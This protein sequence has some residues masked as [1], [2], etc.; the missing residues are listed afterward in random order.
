MTAEEIKKVKEKRNSK[1][2]NCVGVIEG[3]KWL[4]KKKWL[5][6]GQ[7]ITNH[8]YRRIIRQ[9]NKELIEELFRRGSVE[10]PWGL[11]KLQVRKEKS[12]I[13]FKDGKIDT[14]LNIDWGKTVKLWSQ[15]KEA[16][17][18]KTLVKCDCKYLYHIFYTKKETANFKNRIYYKLRLVREVYKRMRDKIDNNELEAFLI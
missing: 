14:N 17:K 9:L 8:Q 13:S 11:G 1:I 7:E 3:Y 10:F 4:K 6:V 2:K 12:R 18:N 15:D 16:H 5:N